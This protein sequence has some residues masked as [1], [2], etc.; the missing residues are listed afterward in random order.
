MGALQNEVLLLKEEIKRLTP[1]GG[2]EIRGGGGGT[3]R[4]NSLFSEVEERRLKG[5]GTNG[6]YTN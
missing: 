5:E 1:G 3:S 6:N 2:E 4:G